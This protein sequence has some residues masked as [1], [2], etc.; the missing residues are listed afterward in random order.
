MDLFTFMI[1]GGLAAIIVAICG[2]W[3]YEMEKRTLSDAERSLVLQ[4]QMESVK[5]N[6]LFAEEIS[7]GNLDFDSGSKS[8]EDELGNALLAMQKSLVISTKREQ[9]E[10]YITVG[11]NAISE[12]LRKHSNDI[13]ALSNDLI[14]G[15]VKYMGLNQGDYF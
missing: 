15:I 8:K 10:K 5:Q 2:W 13:D 4:S 9:E 12:I 1:H 11:I 6:I 7:R 3:S 14:R